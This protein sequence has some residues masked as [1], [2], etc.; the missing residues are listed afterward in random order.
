MLKNKKLNEQYII[1][2]KGQKK[3][4]ILPFDKYE[5]LME[6]LHDLSIIA[7]RRDEPTISLDKLKAKLRRSE[8]I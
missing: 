7:E 8:R 4:V 1:D 5:E 3:A 2:K 6:D